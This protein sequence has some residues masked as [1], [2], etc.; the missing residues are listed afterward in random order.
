LGSKAKN[1]ISKKGLLKIQPVVFLS[2]LLCVVICAVYWPLKNNG[3]I[4]FDDNIYVT[5]NET[6]K[7]GLTTEGIRWAF[8]FN[9]KG[10]WQPLAWLSH[11]LDCELYGLNPAGHHLTNLMIH[12]A[13]TLLLFWLLNRATGCV[14]KSA[15]VAA[16]FA[17]HPLNVESVA[18]LAERKNVL[19]TFFWLLTIFIY[20]YY[21]RKHNIQWYL[22]VVICFILGLMTKPMAVTLPFLMLLLDFWPLGRIQI[23]RLSSQGALHKDKVGSLLPRKVRWPIVVLEK[24]PLLILSAFSVFLSIS[25]LQQMDIM[26]SGSIAPLNLRIANALV[27]YV[28]YINKMI[29]P[30]DLAIFYPYPKLLPTWQ[31]LVSVLCLL[32]ISIL[33]IAAIK[34]RPYLS[35]GWLWYVGTLVPVIGIVQTGIWPAM[36]DR[37]AYVPLIGLF[38]I[39]VWGFSDIFRRSRYNKL[40]PVVLCSVILMGFA[41][42]THM[43]LR[44]WV[45]SIPLFQH[46]LQVTGDN[47]IAYYSI[48]NELV[49][50]GRLAKGIDFY[51]SALRLKPEFSQVHNNL[52]V[53]LGRTGNID[54]AVDHFQIALQ[55]KNHY[56]EAH[57]NLGVALRSRGQLLEAGQHYG[58]AL[59][60]DP[61]YAEAYNNLGLLLMQ[62]GKIEEALSYFK[63]ALE[64][65]PDFINARENF[66]KA[67][68][69]LG[70]NN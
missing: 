59:K 6:V 22:G 2:V 52:G 26:V 15:C 25:S 68:L 29:W 38:I 50:E 48:G 40:V 42:A 9:D 27:S 46:A 11:M 39:I 18:W 36:A 66:K 47:E 63:K 5:E 60:L 21:V 28:G 57:N 35:V 55:K 7:G 51:R 14:Y 54:E 4:N 61:A 23:K 1:L 62:Q 64:K 24:V 37:W 3:F 10:Y 70:I 19:S 16:L 49:Q 12:L 67:T 41:N 65:K 44:H 13:N 33:C 31:I 20:T 32:A 43:Q 17:L 45:S 30:H 69:N 34:R 8:R 58:E 53:A 56:A